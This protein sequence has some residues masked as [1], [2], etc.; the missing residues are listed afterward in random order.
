MFCVATTGDDQPSPSG[1]TTNS[2][3]GQNGGLI[4]GVVVVTLLLAAALG[5]IGYVELR[6]HRRKQASSSSSGRRYSAS[7]APRGAVSAGLNPSGPNFSSSSSKRWW[8]AWLE[9]ADDV[10]EKV[11]FF[12]VDA[13]RRRKLRREV[14]RGLLT[15]ASLFLSAGVH[16]LC[17][18]FVRALLLA[19]LV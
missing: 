10:A 15:D 14:G 17:C 6:R 13:W 2:S 9:A 12:P 16:V 1:G 18:V 4:A 19:L 7:K 3:A 11:I 5:G 8:R